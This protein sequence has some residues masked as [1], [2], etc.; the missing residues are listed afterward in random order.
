MQT[1][2]QLE[3]YTTDI[4]QFAESVFLSMLGLD[5]QPSEAP[6]PAFEVVTAAVYFAGPWKGAVLLQC[7]PQEACEFTTR[8]MGIPKPS[9]FDDD[10]RDAMGEIANI[11]GGNLK[12]ILPHGVV[13]SMPSVVAGTS[14]TLRICG[15]S[16]ILRLAF[17]CEAGPFWLTIVG[18]SDS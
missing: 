16:P 15:D 7:D 1:Q 2:L 17:S 6:L 18:V 13:L 8:L 10:V 9:Q 12:P 3:Q 11:L 14:S 5:V 4:Y